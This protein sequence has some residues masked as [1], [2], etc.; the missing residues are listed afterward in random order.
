M[1]LLHL[2]LQNTKVAI[3]VFYIFE[4]FP[5]RIA[6]MDELLHSVKMVFLFETVYLIEPIVDVVEPL[7][8]EINVVKLRLYFIGYILKVDIVGIHTTCQLA[9][10]R[11]YTLYGVKSVDG[12]AEILSYSISLPR[13]CVISLV[14]SGLYVL[15][16]AHLV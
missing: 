14:E 3:A 8:V 1:R 7:W 4:L 9:S 16:V 5:Q 11:H 13:E 2:T 6:H 15:V 12:C 10:L